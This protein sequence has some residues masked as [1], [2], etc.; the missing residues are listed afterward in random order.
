MIYAIP[1][2]TF[3]AVLEG[4]ATGLVGTVGVRIE[5]PDGSNN[6]A[7]TTSGIVELEAGSGAYAASGLVAP[8][9]AGTYIVIWDTGGGSP[10]WAS[11]ELTVTS[12]LPTP[13][14]GLSTGAGGATLGEMTSELQNVQGLDVTDAEAAGY[15]NEA[16][17]ELC[18]QS[19]WTRANVELGPTISGQAA[20]AL[21]DQIF[22]PLDIYV[23]GGRYSNADESVVRE[24]EAGTFRLRARAIWWLSS[25]ASGAM[26]V[27]LYPTPSEALTLTA[28]AVVYPDDMVDETDT[29]ACPRNFNRGLI[30]YAQ[31]ISLGGS[32]DDMDRKQ[33]HMDEFERQV[34]RLRQHRIR[35]SS[36]RNGAQIRVI[37][38]TA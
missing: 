23:D 10:S 8:D 32:E 6:T 25:D 24:I 20:Y 4:A 33:L 7:R 38:M 12:R 9:T 16:Q 19:G 37:G 13:L 36:G 30:E 3:T 17:A 34:I 27:S 22:E 21:A 14:S 35:R 29:P 28:T 18:T 26:H 31:A 2:S 15:L 5:N 1:G 11:E